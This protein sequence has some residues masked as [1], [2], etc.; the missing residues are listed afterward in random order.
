M[1][2][3][4]NVQVCA[5]RFS[6][7]PHHY[8]VTSQKTQPSEK[9]PFTTLKSGTNII[10]KK[11]WEFFV[12]K[13]VKHASGV[14]RLKPPGFTVLS[15]TTTYF[16]PSNRRIPTPWCHDLHCFGVSLVSDLPR[17]EDGFPKPL[18][19]LGGSKMFNV[20]LC[21]SNH[22]GLKR[23][24]ITNHFHFPPHGKMSYTS[25]ETNRS[26]IS[27]VLSAPTLNQ[28]GIS[29]SLWFKTSKWKSEDMHGINKAQQSHNGLSRS[30][31]ICLE[32]LLHQ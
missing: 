1:S 24:R 12:I 19:G 8:I 28:K 31:W 30:S 32:E 13:I 15:K 16:W 7:Q 22:V 29:S 23:P 6:L 9:T 14:F 25:S 3:N 26:L 18:P 20:I 11:S 2:H 4:Q 5:R 17:S 21:R 27:L 10:L